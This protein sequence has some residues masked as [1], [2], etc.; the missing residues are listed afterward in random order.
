MEGSVDSPRAERSTVVVAILFVW[1]ASGATFPL[2]AGSFGASYAGVSSFL[3]LIATATLG[4]IV[5][6]ERAAVRVLWRSLPAAVLLVSWFAASAAWSVLPNLTVS[7]VRERLVWHVVLLLF[8]PLLTFQQRLLVLWGG[9]GVGLTHSALLALVD[10]PSASRLGDEALNGAWVDRNILSH[11][12]TLA[13]ASGFALALLSRRWLFP[14]FLQGVLALWLIARSGSRT[15]LF[16]VPVVA[17]ALLALVPTVQARLRN[18]GTR[19]IRLGGIVGLGMFAAATTLGVVLFRSSRYWSS[20]FADSS[21]LDRVTYWKRV[22]PFLV[23]RPVTGWGFGNALMQS[24]RGA[25][26]IR[27]DPF[28]LAHLHSGFVET[29]ADGGLV[30]LSLLLWLIGIAVHRSWRRCAEGSFAVGVAGIVVVVTTVVVNLTEPDFFANLP[31]SFFALVAVAAPIKVVRRNGAPENPRRVVAVPVW[32]LATGVGLVAAFVAVLGVSEYNSVSKRRPLEGVWRACGPLS[33]DSR[34]LVRQLGAGS[35]AIARLRAADPGG[36][37]D[38]SYDSFTL[39]GFDRPA[40][41]ELRLQCGLVNTPSEAH[42]VLARVVLT[43]TPGLARVPEVDILGRELTTRPEL[44]ERFSQDGRLSIGD[45][46]RWASDVPATD[47]S[48]I[49]LLPG[50][51]T[52]KRMLRGIDPRS[53]WWTEML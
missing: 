20:T 26:I 24:D 44:V 25:K 12:A 45:A 3:P 53:P 32:I 6:R 51:P 9:F 31:P 40:I 18:G 2:L 23:D 47:P 16:A 34:S 39:Q 35:G 52:Y 19:A 48:Y 22:F 7:L 37:V 42:E 15:P 38:T 30:A 28:P 5:S 29:V 21:F 17:V 4:V 13:L 11:S 50:S 14:I 46:L 33:A 43:A 36:E 49:P 8:V 10:S 27:G 1:I 41:R